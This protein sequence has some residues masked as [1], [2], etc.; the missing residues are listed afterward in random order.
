MEATEV[1][2]RL[3][4]LRDTPVGAAYTGGDG[5]R[6]GDE[7]VWLSGCAHIP[8]AKPPD[9]VWEQEAFRCSHFLALRVTIEAPGPAHRCMAI[10]DVDCVAVGMDTLCV[11]GRARDD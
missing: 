8:L 5:L 6:I 3:D 9:K 11:S 10:T 2:G 4:H 7:V 1:D